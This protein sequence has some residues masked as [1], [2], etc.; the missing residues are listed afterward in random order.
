VT[1]AGGP[2]DPPDGGPLGRP[3]I[4]RDEVDSTNSLLKRLAQEG[5]PEGTTVVARAQVRGRGQHS[6][7]WFSP[8]G[9]GLYL[10]V[11]LRPPWD[12]G[13]AGLLALLA[14][15]AVAAACDE[16][17]VPA[18]RLKWPNDVLTGGRKI[19]GVLVEPVLRGGR[20]ESAVLGLGI[21]VLH[22]AEDFPP[23]LRA[24]ATSCRLA[25]AVTDCAAVRAA[26]LR[27]LNRWYGAARA[28][29]LEQL[30][31]AWAERARA[32]APAGRAP[33]AAARRGWRLALPRGGETH[34]AT[35]GPRPAA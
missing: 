31:S 10:S 23:E 2:P 11:L 32:A 7:P 13:D 24:T 27:A 14:G 4:E 21:N 22:A 33:P 1:P 17:G 9:L 3:L 15:L 12:A 35:H 28:D 29:G 25:G 8:P 26:V 18:V 34:H 19:G 16:V 5:A 6:R 20:L 30:Y